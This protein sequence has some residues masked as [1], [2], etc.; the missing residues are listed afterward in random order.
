MAG[1]IVYYYWKVDDFLIGRMLGNE[2]LGYYY[3]LAFRIPEYMF[4]IKAALGCLIFTTLCRLSDQEKQLEGYAVLTRLS[5]VVTGLPVLGS[6]LYGNSIIVLL[7]GEQWK[8]A[9][10]S[11][12]I[13]MV[14]T[15]LRIVFSYHGDLLKSRGLTWTIPVATAQN[16]VILTLLVWYLTPRYGI[17]WTATGVLLTIVAGMPLTLYFYLRHLGDHPFRHVLR[18]GLVCALTYGV[19]WVMRGSLPWSIASHVGQG[20]ALAAVYA[21]FIWAL[22]RRSVEVV[23]EVLTEKEF[24]R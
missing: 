6:L 18:P 9:V 5:T 13:L 22:D 19:G 1:T 16:A 11:F 12:Q 3:Y 14:T 15:A 10:V 2:Q 20:V 7:F 4:F 23:R 17:A 24:S 8:P 21:G